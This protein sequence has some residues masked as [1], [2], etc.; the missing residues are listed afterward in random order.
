MDTQFTYQRM[1][2]R[3]QLSALDLNLRINNFDQ[4][5]KKN[6]KGMF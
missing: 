6:G 3:S 4:K 2:A 5:T 1:I